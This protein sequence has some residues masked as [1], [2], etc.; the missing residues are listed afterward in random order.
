MSSGNIFFS[1]PKNT[2][3]YKLNL[4]AD[5]SLFYFFATIV[6]I[7]IAQFSGLFISQKRNSRTLFI[8]LSASN[9]VIVGSI[10]GSILY[11]LTGHVHLALAGNLL[12]HLVILLVLYRKIGNIF[13]K[14]C[15]RDLGKSWWE[16]CLIPIF[17]FCSFSCLAFFPYT[18]YEYP[19]N[20]LVSIFLMITMLVSYV[21][22]L[23]YLDSESKKAEE[24]WKNVM[25]ESYIK[26]LES[27]NYLVEQSEQNLKILRHDMRHY[28]MTIDSL[29]EQGEYDEIRNI[30]GHIHEVVE[31]NRVNRYCENLIVNTVLLKMAEQAKSLHIT[32][33]PEVLIP[34]QIPVNEYEF[35]MVLANLLENAVSYVKDLTPEQRYINAKIHCTSEYLL[36]DMENECES[37]IP[38]DSI[39]RLPK[40][41]RGANHG[42][43]MQ[44]IQAFCGK[45]GGNIECYCENG[46]FRIILFAKF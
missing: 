33:N 7:A 39:T 5:S 46:R 29:L 32:L 9:Y 11:I 17:F 27:Q 44:S 30:T 13:H 28:S 38:F 31:E 6:Q 21:V 24:Y 36:I 15:E 18:L 4:F 43:G 12:M 35:A 22:V 10:T 41:T 26:G 40:S 20:I 34:R 14:F 25:F 1:F 19:E 23:R 2:G 42:L 45:L 16:L 3:R 8:G 37:E